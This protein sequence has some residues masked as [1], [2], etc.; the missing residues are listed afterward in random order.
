M[1][2]RVASICLCLAAGG[3]GAGIAFAG[4]RLETI[5]IKIPAGVNDGSR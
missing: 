5:D 4:G 2:K 3:A 1:L